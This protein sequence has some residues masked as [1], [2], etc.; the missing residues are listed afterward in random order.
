MHP[1]PPPSLCSL[2]STDPHLDHLVWQ[3]C[4][5]FPRPAGGTELQ[6]GD[7][8]GSQGLPCRDKGRSPTRCLHSPATRARGLSAEPLASVLGGSHIVGL[9]PRVRRAQRGLG[10][11][12]GRP[13]CPAG[14][15]DRWG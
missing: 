9:A 6:A 14:P 4:W 5:A 2:L 12:G 7:V 8:S 11:M 10:E 3:T 15:C 13:S 1:A